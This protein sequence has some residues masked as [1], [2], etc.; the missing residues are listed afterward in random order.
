MLIVADT[1]NPAQFFAACGFFE[2][3]A[4][5]EPGA[6]A[7]WVARGLEL[8]A[9]EGIF[10]RVVDLLARLELRPDTDWDWTGE[11]KVQPFNAV[12]AESGFGLRLDWWEKRTGG[13][14]LWKTFAAQMKALDTTQKLRELAALDAET[15]EPEFLLSTARPST[16]RLGFDPRSAWDA[17]GAGFAPNQHDTLRDAATYAWCELLASVGL[18]TFPFRALDGRLGKYRTWEVSLPIA[19]ARAAAS[20]GLAGVPG[21]R[22]EYRRVMRGKGLSGLGYARPVD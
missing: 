18:Q 10:R 14:S 11:E 7:R 20:G 1:R 8:D 22:F 12:D 3:A 21:Q 2:L 5:C 19:L 15:V 9:H 4:F 6:S 17:D 13:N 16:G